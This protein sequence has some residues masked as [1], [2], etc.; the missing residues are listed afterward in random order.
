MLQAA[1]PS[2]CLCVTSWFAMC[3]PRRSF[4]SACALSLC[5]FAAR[6]RRLLVV[7]EVALCLVLLIGAGL[8]IR[9]LWE[10]RKVQPGFD[11]HN[12]LTMTVPLPPNRYS[13]PAGQIS[14]F[15]DVLTRIRALPGVDSAGV[16][17]S[18]PL[19]GGGSI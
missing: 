10:L 3:G 6:T 16:I 15:Q 18:L 13:S 7:C 9:S 1:A 14:F 5:V 2:S 8:M 11:P 12:V 4:C 19:N 17:D